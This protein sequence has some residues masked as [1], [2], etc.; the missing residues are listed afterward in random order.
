MRTGRQSE[1]IPA[2]RLRTNITPQRAEMSYVSQ[3]GQNLGVSSVPF[4]TQSAQGT[5][6]SHPTVNSAGY[7]KVHEL[8]HRTQ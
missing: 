4:A 8:H 1:R 3:D 6:V 5:Q 2:A 7:V